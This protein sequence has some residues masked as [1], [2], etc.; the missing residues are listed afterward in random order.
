[1]QAEVHRDQ[2]CCSLQPQIVLLLPHTRRR[3]RCLPERHIFYCLLHS[4]F[5]PFIN[6]HLPP[7]HQIDFRTRRD[8]CLQVEEELVPLVAKLRSGTAPDTSIIAG[9]F[10]TDK[11]NP[12]L[13]A[14]IPV[15]TFLEYIATSHFFSNYVSKNR[16]FA[17][18][19]LDFTSEI[20]DRASN[21]SALAEAVVALGILTLPKQSPRHRQAAQYRYSRALRFMHRALSDTSKA[22][23][24]ETMLGVILLG[25]YEVGLFLAGRSSRYLGY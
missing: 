21:R 18:L 23:S 10:D 17:R 8:R 15:S 13:P 2:T 5:K 11:Q 16:T 4:I 1:M 24:D 7:L 14:S 9:D 25:L 6:R 22:T 12:R 3:L 19:D 20:V